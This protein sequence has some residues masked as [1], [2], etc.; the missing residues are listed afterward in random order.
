MYCPKCG[1]Y[2]QG[3]ARFCSNC[4]ASLESANNGISGVSFFHYAGFWRRFVAAFIDGI[5]LWI[6]GII[7]RNIILGFFLGSYM[8]SDKYNILS[9]Y[10]IDNTEN[11]MS[12]IIIVNIVI[13][14]LYYALFESS[15]KQATPGKMALGIMVTDL[16]GN[17]ISFGRATGRYFSKIISFLT[18]LIGYIIAGFTKEKQALHDMIAGTLVIKK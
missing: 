10:I 8:A 12:Y 16:D 15:S 7:M 1:T 18:L 5:I 11:I 17:K 13:A 4:G 3:D 14:W 9:S 2:N 6:V